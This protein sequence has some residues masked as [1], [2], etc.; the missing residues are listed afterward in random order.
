MAT[1]IFYLTHSQRVITRYAINEDVLTPRMKETLAAS[2]TLGDNGP[3]YI[4]DDIG[5]QLSRA[6]FDGETVDEYPSSDLNWG[7]SYDPNEPM[8]D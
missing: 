2:A 6:A 8:E 3:L 7:L 4:D 1:R 5:A